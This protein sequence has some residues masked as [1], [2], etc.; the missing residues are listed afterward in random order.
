MHPML[1][2][3]PEGLALGVTDS[4]M[5]AHKP[6]G[7]AEFKES[8]RWIEERVAEMA[9][10]VPDMRLVYIADREGDFRELFD[11]G[12][13]LGYPA[14]ILVRAVHERNTAE[15]DKLWERVEQSEALGDI[16]FVLPAGKNRNARKVCQTIYVQRATLPPRGK[17]TRPP[18][19]NR[20]CGGC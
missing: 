7:E 16:E 11:K 9:E 2:A 15:G 18:E 12:H 5:W 4:W 13:E 8:I 19:R 3:T 17:K 10:R 20:W 6:K 1:V 14:D